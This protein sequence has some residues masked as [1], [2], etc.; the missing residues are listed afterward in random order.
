MSNVRPRLLGLLLLMLVL[1]LLLT[2]CTISW[3][4][5]LSREAGQETRQQV[6][7]LLDQAGEFVAGFCSSSL[8]PL[9]LA[10]MALAGRRSRKR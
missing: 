10:G 8:L 3:D 4:G 6:D 2:A 5:D 1:G 7:E 9:A